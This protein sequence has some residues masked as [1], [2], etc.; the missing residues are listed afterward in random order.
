MISKVDGV[1]IL[2]CDICGQQAD[3]IF[4]KFYDAVESKKELRW[5]SQRNN[6]EWEDVC[7]DC[8]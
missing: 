6:S 7:P 2:S 4:S 5:K 8:Q 3:M 1:F